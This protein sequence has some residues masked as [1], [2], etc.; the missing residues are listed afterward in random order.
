MGRSPVSFTGGEPRARPKATFGRPTDRSAEAEEHLMG[1]ADELRQRAP[2]PG[3]ETGIQAPPRRAGRALV[4]WVHATLRS[5]RVHAA[6]VLVLGL[7]A[8]SAFVVPTLAP[9]GVSDDFL[10]V[11]SVDSLISDG[12]LLILPATGVTLVFQVGWGALFSAVFGHSFGVLRVATVVFALGSAVAVYGLCRELRLDNRLSAL[13][14]ATFLFNP[15]GVPVLVHL[16][17]G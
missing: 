3:E 7:Y 14:A 11:R 1:V 6:A 4:S 5:G 15:L 9:V 16:H 12:E 13:G 8:A 10:F 2:G 17:V